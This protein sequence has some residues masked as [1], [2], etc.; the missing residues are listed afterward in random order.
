MTLVEIMI[1]LIISSIIAASTFMFFA[2]QQ[3]V[4]ETQ[5]KL[6][7][8]QQN[9]WAAMEILSR[10]TRASGS[11]MFECIRP[12]SYANTSST[13][14]GRYQSTSPSRGPLTFNLAS[15]PTAGVRAYS[16]TNGMQWIPPLW[17]VDNSTTDSGVSDKTDII[18]LAF[19]SQ[20]SGTDIDVMLSLNVTNT[21]PGNPLPLNGANTSNMFRGGE[22]VLLLSTPIFGYGADPSDDR[23]CT[24]FQVTD[25]APNV[26]VLQH[27]SVA[28]D[29][30]VWN[31]PANQ[32][33]M[34]PA[35]GGYTGGS[36]GVRNF[37]TLTWVRFFISPDATTGIPNLMLQQLHRG[38]S[39]G[40]PQVLAEGIEDLQVSFACD[41]G[42][43]LAHD[44]ANVNGT[45]DEG[46]D[47][48]T[49]VTVEW[50]N[51]VD[52][53]SLPA[54]NTDGY[55]NL[56][57]AIRLTLVARTLSP[58]DLVDPTLNGP[59]DVENHVYATPR[60]TDSFRRRVLS[61]TVYPRNNKPL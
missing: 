15:P 8:I 41:T 37:G 9:I 5:T 18:T 46:Y 38:G 28:S 29:G 47:S 1:T 45:L 50:W 20:T 24:M 53:D 61:T 3:R 44:L 32:P 58:D 12:A 56:P 36:A 11:G 39:A 25:Y 33:T 14:G 31:P 54:I 60:P 52:G 26:S 6:L 19:G 57:T 10:Y 21:L 22:F 2:G 13:S 34:F 40:Q 48:P 4:Y 43:L 30:I 27:Q 16:A 23:G 7:N 42:E 55:C 49:K 17:I 59:M 35:S 51:N